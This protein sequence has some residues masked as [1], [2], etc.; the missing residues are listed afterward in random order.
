MNKELT[1]L[2]INVQEKAK[3]LDQELEKARNLLSFIK[4]CTPKET[5]SFKMLNEYFNELKTKNK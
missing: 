2:L 3:K 1:E 4:E 5:T